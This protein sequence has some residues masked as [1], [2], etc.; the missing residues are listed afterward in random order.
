MDQKRRKVKDQTTPADRAR[1]KRC[2][3]IRHLV[4]PYPKQKLT[5]QELA[6]ELDVSRSTV[7]RWETGEQP[8]NAE[9]AQ[10]LAKA[11]GA[12]IEW[13]LSGSG[14]GPTVGHNRARMAAAAI[15]GHTPTVEIGPPEASG[16]MADA[17]APYGGDSD[18]SIDSGEPAGLARPRDLHAD[19]GETPSALG[20]DVNG[21]E[22]MRATLEKIFKRYEE[23]NEDIPFDFVDQY[24]SVTNLLLQYRKGQH[25]IAHD[26]VRA[27]LNVMG[28]K[29]FWF[30][31]SR[32]IYDHDA[33]EGVGLVLPPAE[34]YD[35]RIYDILPQDQADELDR[36]MSEALRTG[37][38]VVLYQDTEVQGTLEHQKKTVI[39]FPGD[40]TVILIELVRSGKDSELG[41]DSNPGH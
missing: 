6:D 19:V 36:A 2:L 4:A 38:E 20:F 22:E 37:K 35:R 14:N 10:K 13:I 12:S 9:D 29:W 40:E 11:S 30:G 31:P 8:V 34:F 3:A 17:S 23:R 5:Q 32:R 21:R 39:P 25:G 24:K 1:G 41:P 27:V 18:H 28:E 7:R 15:S 16:A 26:Q 33:R